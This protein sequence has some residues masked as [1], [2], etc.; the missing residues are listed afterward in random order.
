V[1][2]APA[3]TLDVYVVDLTGGAVARD[4][5]VELRRAGISADRGF[6][7]R[8]M[9]S[10]MKSAGRSGAAFAIIVGEDEVASGVVT[11]RDLRGQ[12]GDDRT[13]E[14]VGRNQLVDHLQKL[15]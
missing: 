11:L 5:S 12:A 9:K 2:G 1:F 10:Q 6:D 3:S 13:Q 14:T 7:Q 15:L 8:S 4:L